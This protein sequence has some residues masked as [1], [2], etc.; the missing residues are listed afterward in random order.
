[1]KKVGPKS[2]NGISI[3]YFYVMCNIIK[4]DGNR[5]MWDCYRLPSSDNQPSFTLIILYTVQMG[6][7]LKYIEKHLN[8]VSL[9]S[10]QS[11]FAVN[12]LII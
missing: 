9:Y 5:R 7:T 10:N 11:L 12:L 6:N 3:L 1:M 8:T 4:F 2:Q